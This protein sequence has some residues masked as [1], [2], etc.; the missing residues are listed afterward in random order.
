M[1]LEYSEVSVRWHYPGLKYFLS[2]CCTK[3]VF[4]KFL[5]ILWNNKDAR[6]IFVA[7]S[8]A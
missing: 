2:Q 1:V 8:S 6:I 5:V 3:R 4:G 7:K